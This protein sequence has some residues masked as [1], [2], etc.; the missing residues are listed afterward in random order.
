MSVIPVILTPEYP[1]LS[2]RLNPTYTSDGS[3]E[4]RSLAPLWQCL[5]LT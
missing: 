3:T 4:T 5:S 2:Q 1:L